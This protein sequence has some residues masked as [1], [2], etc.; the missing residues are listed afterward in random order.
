M[1]VVLLGRQLDQIEWE[2]PEARTLYG[3]QPAHRVEA[4]GAKDPMLEAWAMVAQAEVPQDGAIWT[5]EAAMAAVAGLTTR[6][7]GATQ[8]LATPGC[9]PAAIP[10]A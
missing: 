2:V 3:V 10:K 4:D 1:D 9:H 8:D 6:A 7:A 5:K